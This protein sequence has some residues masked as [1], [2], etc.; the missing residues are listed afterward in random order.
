[1]V[2]T[3]YRIKFTKTGSLQFI[4]HLD[5]N[6]TMTRVLVRAGLPVH[7]SEGFNP[8]PKI[9]FGPPLSIGAESLT[10]FMDFRLDTADGALIPTDVI[11]EKLNK[12]LP[13]EMRVLETYRPDSSL[14]SVSFAEYEI[15]TSEPFDPAP[16]FEKQ[17]ILPKR[18][19][20]GTVDTDIKPMIRSVTISPA[21]TSLRCVLSARPDVYLN[22]EYVASALRLNEYGIIRTKLFSSDENGDPVLFR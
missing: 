6:R 12:A 17:I 13:P 16:I 22:P 9:T 14:S 19:K 18:T 8:H 10:E 5:L 20:K 7:Y 21:K 15:R 4:S 1:M 11:T 2:S 3:P